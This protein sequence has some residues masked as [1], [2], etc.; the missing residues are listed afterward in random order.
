V[1]IQVSRMKVPQLWQKW[2][3]MMA[4][5]ARLDMICRQ[6]ITSFCFLRSIVFA[7]MYVRSA[8]DI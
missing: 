4:H 2:Q 7:V 3:M 5:T 1:G 6:G 8:S